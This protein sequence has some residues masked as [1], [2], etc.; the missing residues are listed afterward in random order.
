MIATAVQFRKHSIEELNKLFTPLSYMQRISKLYEI[1]NIDEVLFTSSFGTK[2]VFL[3]DSVHQIRPEQK[4]HYVDTTYL[5][6]ETL[7]YKDFITNKYGIKT[8]AVYPDKKSNELTT[9][10][11][12][13]KDH[14]RM[15]C[16]INKI[17]PLTP[18]INQHKIWMSG[19]MGTQTRIRGTLQIFEK[20]GDIIKFHPLIDLSNETFEQRMSLHN[21]ERHP[22][23]KEGYG[24]VGCRHCTIKGK[25]REGRWCQTE[26]TECGLHTSYYYKKDKNKNA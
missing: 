7:G 22:L 25:G 18:I 17:A 15:C 14:P 13:W 3:I 23:E 4:I 2:S 26:Q 19:L 12:W 5:F 20:N 1:F 21:L 6:P 11:K 24:S 16:T 10:E 9:A 8:I